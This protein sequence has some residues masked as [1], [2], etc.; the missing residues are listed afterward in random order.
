MGIIDRISEGVVIRA[1]TMIVN[2]FHDANATSAERAIPF[3]PESRAQKRVFRRMTRFGAVLPAEEGRWFLDER[4]LENF[5]KEELAR[6]LGVLALT[7]L[8][9]AGAIALGR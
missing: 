7:G 9:A 6:L 1:Q 4:A 5:R 8:A 3:V 2:R